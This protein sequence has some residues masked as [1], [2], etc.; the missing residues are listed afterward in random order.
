MA[1]NV[2]TTPSFVSV[3]LQKPDESAISA[4]RFQNSLLPI[5]CN[6]GKRQVYNESCSPG[7]LNLK[8]EERSKSTL[9]FLRNKACTPH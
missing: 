2:N 7:A 5:Y 8:L 4:K 6:V 1:S 9:K 3:L